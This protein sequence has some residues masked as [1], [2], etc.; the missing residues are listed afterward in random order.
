MYGANFERAI[1]QHAMLESKQDLDMSTR[2]LYVLRSLA[3]PALASRRAARPPPPVLA[4]VANQ[5]ERD[6]Y[7]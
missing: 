4:E 7:P 3:P 6:K 5:R 1:S 2:V